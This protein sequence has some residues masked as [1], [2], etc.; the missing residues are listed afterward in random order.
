M[1]EVAAAFKEAAELYRNPRDFYENLPATGPLGPPT[2]RLVLWS[3]IAAILDTLLVQIGLRSGERSLFIFSVTLLLSPLIFL[4]LAWLCA[5]IISF[6][7]VL[8]RGKPDVKRAYRAV[9]AAMS[10]FTLDIVLG[11]I[12]VFRL[13]IISYKLALAAIASEVLFAVGRRRARIVF[14]LI[15]VVFIGGELLKVF[16]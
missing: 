5:L 15:G 14:A 9:A 11:P 3:L 12:L 2:R 10:I 16:R 8:M 6:F 4:V 7:V 13:A 1:N